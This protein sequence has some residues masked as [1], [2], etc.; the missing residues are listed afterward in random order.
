L[1]YPCAEFADHGVLL[2]ELLQNVPEHSLCAADELARSGVL[3][4][5]A[6]STTIAA[7]G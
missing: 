1:T 5:V 7:I 6:G 3:T 4:T 2:A